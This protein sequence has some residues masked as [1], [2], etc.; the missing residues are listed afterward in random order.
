[1]NDAYDNIFFTIQIVATPPTIVI[2]P[3]QMS[4]T[5][6]LRF[7]HVGCCRRKSDEKIFIIVS[8]CA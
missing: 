8:I 5:K 3:V 2:A 1:M 4:L 7:V 6:S